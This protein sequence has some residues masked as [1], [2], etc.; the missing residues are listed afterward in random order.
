MHVQDPR[1]ESKI[2]RKQRWMLKK[3][4]K[5][6][7]TKLI[8]YVI[9]LLIIFVLLFPHK[10]WDG[11]SERKTAQNYS[12]IMWVTAFVAVFYKAIM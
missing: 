3:K 11:K 4:E 7:T 5:K 8:L 12:Y 6:N 1:F 2:Q 9:L 10:I